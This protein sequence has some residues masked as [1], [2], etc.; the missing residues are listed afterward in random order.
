MAKVDADTTPQNTTATPAPGRVAVSAERLSRVLRDLASELRPQAPRPPVVRPDSSLERDLG[1]DSLAR[2]ELVLRLE[3]AFDLRVAEAEV[4]EAETPADLLRLLERAAPGATV[5]ATWTTAIAPE[6]TEGLPDAIATLS[7]ALAFHVQAHPERPHIRLLHAEPGETTLSYGDLWAGAQAVAAGL[8]DRGLG[9][10]AAV[11]IMLPTCA[12]FFYAFFGALLAGGVPV[13]IYPPLRRSQIAEHL[14]R[15][16]RIL[17]NAQ[18]PILITSAEAKLFGRLVRA[19]VPDLRELA[20]VAELRTRGV[21]EAWPQ[22]GPERLAL[23]QYTSGSTGDPKGVMLSHGNL[24][25]NIRG[26]RDALA[27]TS[28]DVV[29]SWL[30]LYHDMGLIGTWLGS[31]CCACPFVVMPPLVFLARPERWLQAI[32][33]Q[34]GTL[35]AAPNFAYELCLRRIEDR[36]IAGLD[37]SSWRMAGNGAERVSFATVTQFAERF[38]RYGFRADAMTPMYGLAESAVALTVSPLGRG[39]R[40]E[41]VRRASLAAQGRAVAA[42]PGDRHVVDLVSCGRPLPSHEVRVVDAQGRELGDRQEGRIEFRG[43]SATAGYMRAP[44][45]TAALI[46]DGWLDSGDTGYIAEGELFVTGRIKD[47]IIRAG[48]N[49]YP[50]EIE[51]AV[52]DLRQVRKGRVAVFASEDRRS[53]TERLIVLAETRVRDPAARAAL[54]AEIAGVIAELSEVPPDEIVLAR[55]GSVLKT[56]NGKVRRAACRALYERGRTGRPPPALWR[57]VAGLLQASVVPEMRR[58]R[59]AA[60]AF[61]FA[62]SFQAVY[63]LLAPVVFLGVVL[64]PTLAGRRRLFHW[65]ARAMLR[66]LGLRPQVRGREHLPADRRCVLVANHASYIDGLVLAAVLPPG[67]AFVA[68]RELVPTPIAGRFLKALGTAFVERFD[69]SGGVED[70]RRLLAALGESR[71]LVVF[72]EGT[73]DRRPGLRSFHMGAFVIAAESG[74]PVI[75]VGVQGTRAVLRDDSRFARRG[76]IGVTFAPALRP[77]GSDWKAALELRDRAREA[78]LAR[79]GEP[80]LVDQPTRR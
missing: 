1:I 76:R 25:A 15:Q 2:V 63:R 57:Q 36:D 44:D 61:L 69:P 39:P 70:A 16:A 49:L 79:C 18:A 52:G 7:E 24:L 5:E 68:K 27:V 47:I 10:G 43:P 78:V 40:H 45:K 74:V 35:S 13:P 56:A 72:P 51:D 66:L 67:F 20:S 62:A 75:P 34:R 17:A 32:H 58:A 46:R 50:D 60:A 55:P 41:R 48:R 54:R 71:T 3:R 28:R 80:D 9:P 59:R 37:L 14:R 65:S 12:D 29:V 23:V 11:G 73:F 4:M 22:I 26:L 38:A 21:P 30:P 19:Q 31:L 77:R 8:C 6:A 33:R 53:G 42:K 64:L